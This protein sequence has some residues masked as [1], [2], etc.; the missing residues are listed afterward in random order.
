MP[1][2]PPLWRHRRD[3]QPI[4]TGKCD[5]LVGAAATGPPEFGPLGKAAPIRSKMLACQAKTRLFIHI[6]LD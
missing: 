1:C 4:R 3:F 5:A 6:S 2:P